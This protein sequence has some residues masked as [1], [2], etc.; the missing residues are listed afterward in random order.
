MLAALA[1]TLPVLSGCAG[2]R[3]GTESMFPANI[4]TVHVPVFENDTFRPFLGERLT[5][6][7]VK[8]IEA[9]TP[10]KVTD[11]AS[12]DTILTGRLVSMRKTVL[13]QERN[14]NPRDLETSFQLLVQWTDRRGDPL[15]PQTVVPVSLF[16]IQVT[17]AAHFVPEAGQSVST[18]Q[19]AAIQRLARQIVSQMNAPW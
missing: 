14:G 17:E 5:E 11:A 10:Y 12:A 19:Q 4:Q 15:T 3:F 2:Y 1:A 13:A 16:D 6:A 9:S 7:V 8:E 18:S